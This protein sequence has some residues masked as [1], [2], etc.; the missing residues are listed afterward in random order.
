MLFLLVSNG[1]L[2]LKFDCVLNDCHSV[3]LVSND[4]L[5]LKFDMLFSVLF[6]VNDCHS[7]S[8]QC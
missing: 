5:F 7:V 6:L 8:C 3:L 4:K 2:F 1:K